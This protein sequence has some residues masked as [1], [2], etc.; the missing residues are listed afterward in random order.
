MALLAGVCFSF[1][2]IG[3][4]QVA[5]GLERFD[6]RRPLANLRQLVTDL[7]WMAAWLSGWVG[8]G[9]Y[10][11]ALALAPLSLVQAI[12]AGGIGMLALGAHLFVEP[13]RVLERRAAYVATVGLILVALSVR[14]HGES[15]LVSLHALEITIVAGLGV[16]L[17]CAAV[18]RHIGLAIS[19]GICYGVGDVATKGAFSG[20]PMLFVFVAVSYIAAFVTLQLAFQRSSLLV[21]AGLSFLLSNV[22]P[23]ACGVLLFGEQP[24]DRTVAILRYSGFVIVI[25]GAVA[26]SAT[27]NRKE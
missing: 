14:T 8:W 20:V 9:F 7:Q 16:A 18:S 21:S 23:L 22:I 27:A 1:S 10:I 12:A 15:H 26:I 3:Q 6:L 11:G 4:H 5:A 2:Y 25:L 19:S 13:L 17:L 24:L